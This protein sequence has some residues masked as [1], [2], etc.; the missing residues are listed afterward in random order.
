MQRPPGECP[1]SPAGYSHE[2]FALSKGFFLSLERCRVASLELTS[3]SLRWCWHGLRLLNALPQHPCSEHL[4]CLDPTAEASHASCLSLRAVLFQVRVW[5]SSCLAMP[6]L[7]TLRVAS[8]ISIKKE[9]QAS[10]TVSS[11]A[12]F[13]GV[14]S[15]VLY[16]NLCKSVSG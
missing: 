14:C 13:D 9:R 7:Q 4:K 16:L 6:L 3:C 12:S 11:L 5:H 8:S 10:P 2:T 15:F 1:L